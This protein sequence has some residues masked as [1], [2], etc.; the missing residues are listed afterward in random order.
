MDKYYL[1]A[2]SFVDG[3]GHGQ[4]RIL[5]NYFKG[6]EN[7]WSASE[8]ELLKS[9]F[10]TQE[11]IDAL[12]TLKKQGVV[13]RLAQACIDKQINIVTYL[14]DEYPVNLKEILRFPVCL[15]YK[16]K[17]LNEIKN[18]LGIVGPRKSTNYAKDVVRFFV[19][20]FSGYEMTIV[21]GGARGIDTVSHQAALK[22]GLH[23]V[24]VLG[25]GL[26][27][28]YPTENG[29]LF[30][31]IVEQGTLLSEYP[32]GSQPLAWHFP[33]RNRII[34]GLSSG[35]LLAEAGQKSGSL[36][37]AEFALDQGREVYCVPGDIF[38]A[39]SFGVHNLLKQGAKLTSIP[40]DIL[41]DYFPDINFKN[42]VPINSPI[43]QKACQTELI[44]PE[45]KE[46][47]LDS[48]SKEQREVLQILECDRPISMDEIHLQCSLDIGSLNLVLLEL[49]ILG[50]LHMDISKRK[51]LKI[52]EVD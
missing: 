8:A 23:T 44:K 17:P 50:Y 16:G 18:P 26:D 41:E 12:F 43:T 3:C 22:N 2:L 38:S 31:T 9:K 32:P 19:E 40:E 5:V 42:I 52:R 10:L 14:D 37:T 46:H 29:K 30:N 51:Y 27:V 33:A 45:P 7:I 24:A 34:S 6:A 1:A 36:I 49:E 47:D 35:V 39:N 15:Y 28:T 20:R 4:T 48:L 21:S 25:C 13:E 11:S